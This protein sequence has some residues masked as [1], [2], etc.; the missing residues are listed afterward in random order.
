M[1]VNRNLVQDTHG[2]TDSSTKPQT[3]NPV[4]AP[5]GLQVMK[6]KVEFRALQIEELRAS[7]P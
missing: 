3:T 7:D 6:G 2:D 5:I 1:W 4:K